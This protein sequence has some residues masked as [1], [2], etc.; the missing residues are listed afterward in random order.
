MNLYIYEEITSTNDLGF[1]STFKDGDILWAESQTAGRGQRGNKW[2]DGYGQNATFSVVLEP[3]FLSAQEQFSISQ[4]TALAL[5]DTLAEFGIESRIKWTNDIY[6]GDRKIAGVL[7]ENRL[8]GDSI[9][10]SVVGIGLNIN[11]VTFDESL[12]NPTSM[13]L[14]AD[15]RF[16]REDVVRRVHRN[17]AKRISMVEQK[18][19][20]AA[21][22]HSLLYRVGEEHD[23][24]ITAC[25]SVK[26]ATII[27]VE[28][29]GALILQYI[30]GEQLSYQFREVEFIIA[31]RDKK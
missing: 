20:I 8:Q 28:D 5:Y 18:Q 29:K 10:R 30:D 22:Y 9:A 14:V 11:Q 12:P 25:G 2:I 19:D 15:S 1:Q 4:A 24:L 16:S 21:D 23:Y 13:A 6:V 7:I 27:G 26:R 3:S 17:L 31:G